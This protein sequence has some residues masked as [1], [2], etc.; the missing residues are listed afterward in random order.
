MD[1]TM[2]HA[3]GRMIEMKTREQ[4]RSRWEQDAKNMAGMVDLWSDI[5]GLPGRAFA[6]IRAAFRTGVVREARA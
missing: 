2:M 6:A 1:F 5:K 3:A 4:L